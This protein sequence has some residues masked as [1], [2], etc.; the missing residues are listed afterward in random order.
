MT[1]PPGNRARSAKPAERKKPLTVLEVHQRMLASGLITEL[2]NR[3]ED[4]DDADD[5]PIAIE[6]EPLSETIIREWR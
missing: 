3:A 4:I 6:G 5:L 2:P 1:K